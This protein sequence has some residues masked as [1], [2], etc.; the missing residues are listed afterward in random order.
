MESSNFIAHRRKCDSKD[1]T[2]QEHLIEVSLIC[3]RL[4]EKVVTPDAG[5]LLGLL[6][7]FGKYSQQF[8]IYL[9]SATGMLNPDV[10]DEYM[11]ANAFKGKIDHSTAGAQWIWQRLKGYDVQG[12]LVGQILAVCLA[13][14]HG[15][16]IDC[17]K[18]GGENG[19][20]NRINKDQIKTH[21]Q[22]CL[23]NVDNT[24]L[25][26]LDDLATDKFL[27]EFWNKLVLLVAPEKNESET[28]KQFR[29][30][31]FL[32]F[33]FSC[34]IDADRIDSADFENPGNVRFRS[35]LPVAWQIAIDRLEA[36][37]AS[38]PV[39]NEIDTARREISDQCKKRAESS[40]GIYTLTVPTGGGKTFASMRYALHHAKKH[41]LDHIIYIIPYTSI[42]EQNAGE[43]RKVLERDSD[44][45]PW[46]LEH[47]SNLEPET[48]TWHSKLVTENWDVPI[49]FTTMVQFLEVLLGGGT[50][51]ARRMHNIANSVLVFDEIQSLPINCVHLF[52][53]AIQFFV[54][55]ARSTAL[56]CTATQPLLDDLKLGK[57]KGQLTLSN[58]HELVD[59]MTKVFEQF[60]RVE[61]KDWVRPE[62]WTEQEL[63][64]LMITQLK[65]KGNCLVIV[66]TKKWARKLYDVCQGSVAKN[67]LF[68]L[69]TSL[70][71]AH[72][73]KIFN[74]VRQ[75][76][77]A[78]LPVLCIS[79][80]L[81]EAGVDVDFNSVIRFLAGLD[82]IAQAAGRCN[83]NGH[84]DMAQVYVVNPKSE[85]I[86]MLPDIKEGREKALR[87]FSEKNETEL[88]D[89]EVMSLYF[90]YYFYERANLMSYPLTEKQAGRKDSL[91]SLLGDNHLNIGMEKNAVKL[92]QSFKTAGKAFRA[93]NSPTQAVIVPCDDKGKEIIAGLCAD[94]EPAKAFQLL[95]EA[96]RYSVN[97]FPNVWRQLI[98]AEAVSPVQKG[99]GIYYLDERYYS[100]DFGLSTEEVNKMDTQII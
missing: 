25:S 61:I 10:D 75:R 91:L 26:K 45:F 11:D 82:S 8:Q 47:H 88:L 7:D 97:V 100:K 44:E 86:D 34:L 19:F 18:P 39:R 70:C 74:T 6:H 98:E 64:E 90:S 41:K 48:Q 13:S 9:Q 5:E 77:D 55:H 23:E 87:I 35:K 94:F 38:F 32:R 22:E 20:S 83:R 85:D 68:H 24:V 43:I 59:D 15:G 71:P 63:G 53:N 81:I 36:K 28:I 67:S 1:Q 69:S 60:K 40:Q 79:T 78:E 56:L 4:A 27:Q 58:D 50:R 96:Q 84:L 42:I 51:G 31:F 72:R 54:D 16:L 30:G 12:K 37:L 65:E 21:I 92:Q 62:G 17:L 89:P 80:Q 73:K 99:E 49:I 3:R 95:K 14:H 93:I 46:V 52:C 76:L 29:L 57:D 66:N 33:L 2:V